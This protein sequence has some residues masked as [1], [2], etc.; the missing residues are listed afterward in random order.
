[1]TQKRVVI[2]DASHSVFIDPKEGEDKKEKERPG[3]IGV[4]QPIPNF[5][6]I[7]WEIGQ[8]PHVVDGGMAMID[9]GLVC[10]S[11]VAGKIG[12]LIVN[13]VMTQLQ[14]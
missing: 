7:L 13:K 8:H 12:L 5:A 14:L 9:V 4:L 6:E 11:D 10:H 3:A 2:L 1:M